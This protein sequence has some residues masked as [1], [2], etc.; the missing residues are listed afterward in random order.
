M[1][2]RDPS[3]VLNE[4]TTVQNPSMPSYGEVLR[5]SCREQYAAALRI[6]S[7]IDGGPDLGRAQRLRDCRQNAWFAR[8][9]ESGQVRVA[10]SACSLRW[11][12]VCAGARRNFVSHEIAEWL[13]SADHP[14]LITLTLRHSESALEEQIDHLYNFFREIRRLKD[15]KY[16]VTGGVWFFQ[17]HRSKHDGLWHPHLHALVTGK[18]LPRRR[19]S[20]MWQRV[21]LDSE[22]IDIR[23]IYEP[24]AVANDV[25][26][27]ATSPGNLK[28]LAPDDGIDL[29]NALHGRRICGTWGTARGI[30]L[31]PQTQNEKGKWISLGSWS[32]VM[33]LY[34]TDPDARA[35]VLSWKTGMSLSEGISCNR[36]EQTINKMIDYSWADYDFEE[37]YSDERKPP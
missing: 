8:N 3:L 21:T 4:Q 17:V 24:R 23:T 36:I 14:K 6:Y 5:G 7:I 34:E 35:I 37:V 29:V 19:L 25:A 27:Y 18:Y 30:H 16:A 33:G 1:T 26:R 15:F 11:C 10:A 20:R 12:P 9:I 13:C 28:N 31:R 2:S 22:V 32:V